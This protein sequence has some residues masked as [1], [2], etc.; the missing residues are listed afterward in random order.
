[1]DVAR[2]VVILARECGMRLDLQDIEIESLVPKPLRDSPS[3][4]TFLADLP[5]V[6]LLLS[7]DPML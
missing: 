2:K 3:A 7:T 1:M 5:Q 6:Q 4:D